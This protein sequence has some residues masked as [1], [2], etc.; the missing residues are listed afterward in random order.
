MGD[1]SGVFRMCVDQIK[2][3]YL[4]VSAAMKLKKAVS[5][6]CLLI[7]WISR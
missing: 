4:G 3:K 5:F 2:Y 1:G 7:S 6:H